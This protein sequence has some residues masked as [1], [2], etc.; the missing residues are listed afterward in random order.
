MKRWIVPIFLLFLVP[1]QTTWADAL[2]LDTVKPDLGVLLVYFVGFFAGEFRGAAAGMI[3]G[4][5]EDLF[6]A[7]PMGLNFVTKALVGTLSGVLGRFFLNVTAPVT[8]VLV[9]VLSL[10]SGMTLAFIHEIALEG[11][12]LAEVLQWTI[13]PE[14]LYNGILGGILYWVWLG[15]IRWK[16]PAS[17]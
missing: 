4:S 8:T 16:D 12:P 9:F 15:R 13:L 1:V 10:F 2:R 5:L 7:G 6:S 17:A 11:V 14:A 3:A